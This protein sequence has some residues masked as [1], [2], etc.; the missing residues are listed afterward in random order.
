MVEKIAKKYKTRGE[1]QKNNP[2]AYKWTRENGY[3]DKLTSHMEP[4]KTKRLTTD[5]FISKS[6]DVHGEKF[7]YSKTNYKSF[8]TPVTIICPVHG[9]F[10]QRPVDHIHTGKHGC[11]KCGFEIR[12][13]K[14][15]SNLDEFLRKARRIHGD[16][17]DYSKSKY[18]K[19]DKPVEIICKLHGPFWMASNHHISQKQGCPRCGEIR[20][21]LKT[22]KS[23][24][25]FVNDAIKV[26]GNIY[27][28]SKTNY[29]TSNDKVVIIC[30]QHGEFEQM[31][32]SHLSGRGCP[33]C[34]GN[35]ILNTDEFIKR[36]KEIHGD[37]FDYS[38][39]NYVRNDIPVRIICPK[40]GEFLQKPVIH[41]NNQSDC[42]Q[43]SGGKQRN[44][45]E[46]IQLAKEIHGNQYDYSKVDYKK[47][48]IKVEIICS[49]HG[50][51]FQTPNSHLLGQG[52]PSCSE[53]KGEKNIDKILK[54]N[55][56]KFIRQKRFIDCTNTLKG[57][58]CR[59]LPFDFYL[60]E[61]NVLIEFDGAQHFMPV[62]QWG[63]EEGFKMTKKRDKIKNQYCKK[64]G[65]KLI[66][67]P[68]TMKKEEI[69]PY[70]LKELGIK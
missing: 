4:P 67:I 27:D 33:V 47:S 46:F 17:Y 68:Y 29:I 57:T 30:P 10:Q 13:I 62:E 45:Q 66:R 20:A 60:T 70:I 7:D 56:I 25:D 12:T 63:G 22:R 43:C 55:N 31:P 40:H 61:K 52:C 49:K 19:S 58:S 5:E 59:Q 53:S 51:F 65:I 9:E 18:T 24:E 32:P 64:N 28:Y 14:N 34:A 42:P 69:E 2:A 38:Q 48:Q 44:T 50:S 21:G 11:P 1:F 3:L 35:Q 15:T 23:S 8:T 6:K 54:N 26:H 37:K 16:T 36:A 41:I 39:V